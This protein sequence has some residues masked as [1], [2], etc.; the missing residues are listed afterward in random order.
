M[1]NHDLNC[2]RALWSPVLSA[3]SHSLGLQE[4]SLQRA[5]ET[6]PVK[7][8]FGP[9]AAV[10]AALRMVVL[11]ATIESVLVVLQR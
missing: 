1:S 5:M 9:A 2:E 10:R 8:V 7:V 3:A 4:I 6:C 11:A